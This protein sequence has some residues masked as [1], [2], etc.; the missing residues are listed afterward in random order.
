MSNVASATFIAAA[1]SETKRAPVFLAPLLVIV[2]IIGGVVGNSYL[3]AQP[4][5]HPYVELALTSEPAGTAAVVALLL[6]DD[7]RTLA[8]LLGGE[9]LQ[10]LAK[11]VDPLDDIFE[12]KYVGGVERKGERFASYVL[13]GRNSTK[14]AFAVGVVF[15]LTQGKIVG[16]N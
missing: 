11:A 9:T 7:S 1:P 2:G 15:R 10:A 8:S 4:A 16:V 12:A 3:L 5:Q 6:A 13:S 14:E